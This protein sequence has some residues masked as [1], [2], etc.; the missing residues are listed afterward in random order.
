MKF[1]CYCFENVIGVVILKPDTR[2]DK[3]TD[4]K[5]SLK[6]TSGKLSQLCE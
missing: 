3:E 5:R 1:C 6:H 4:G 2:E